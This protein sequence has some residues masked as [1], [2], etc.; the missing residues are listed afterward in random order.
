MSGRVHRTP[1]ARADLLAVHDYIDDDN[2][3]AADRFLA[4]AEDCFRLL[5]DL[6]EVGR[7]WP[8][9]AESLGQVRT[10][11][12]PGFHNYLVFYRPTADG[13]LVLAVLHSARDLK[14]VFDDYF[15]TPS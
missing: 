10:Y 12:I 14:N 13:I 3:S 2:P 15:G 1:Q 4:A 11:P 9:A 6:P 7:L 5:C 8:S